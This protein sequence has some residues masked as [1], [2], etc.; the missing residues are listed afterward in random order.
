MKEETTPSGGFLDMQYWKDDLQA[1]FVLF[2]MSIAFGLGI[3]SISGFPPMAGLV[4]AVVGM[5]AL[6]LYGGSNIVI[7][8]AAAALAPILHGAVMELGHGDM[9]LGYQR[10]LTVIL[11]TGPIMFLFGSMG[12]TRKIASLLSHAVVSGLLASI[13]IILATSRV[14]TFT[15]VSIEA[16]A[17]IDIIHEAIILGRVYAEYDPRVLW[18]SLATFV[19]LIA[20]TAL[21]GRFAFFKRYPPQLF[22]IF[23][24]LALGF[25]IPFEQSE[26]VAI[27]A[28]LTS[29]HLWPDL[30]FVA[31]WKEG[32]LGVLIIAIF[33]LTLVDS[34]ETVATTMGID[35]LDPLR[36]KSDLNRVVSAM[37]LANFVSGLLGG[38][39]NIPGGAK[40]TM[41]AMVGAKTRLVSLFSI[42]FVI[43][44]VIFGRDVMNMIPQSGLAMII[45]FTVFK[46]CAPS[47]WRHFYQAGPDQFLVFLTTFAV[48]VYS[49]HIEE[50]LIAGVF[51][52]FVSVVVL[53]LYAVRNNRQGMFKAV[54]HVMWRL[55]TGPEIT[56][57]A[58]PNDVGVY[59]VTISGIYAF[60]HSLRLVVDQVPKGAKV[61][62]FHIDEDTYLLDGGVLEH[63]H[64]LSEE[65]K[66]VV[67]MP[68][69]LFRRL[70][71]HHPH[72]TCF[73]NQQVAGLE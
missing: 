32:V 60:C 68:E 39:S 20:L 28:S 5:M 9:T 6:F 46:M 58:D 67:N 64:E 35:K 41:S 31:M 42:I 73:R 23:F 19:F 57:R 29:F 56:V 38:L 36:R 69:E 54:Y 14:S 61:V 50:G 3:A 65:F 18:T 12:W 72:S 22:A 62:H 66:G 52:Q 17:P 45:V 27:P 7:C 13:A 2:P 70:S 15:G 40:S 44:A 8:G 25:V 11:L 34:A 33:T 43:T 21:K 30:N 55:W 48:G 59:H 4:S 37:G 47:I 16:K 10:T 1:A 24:V 49:G 63:L 51:L 53:S 26:R 71:R